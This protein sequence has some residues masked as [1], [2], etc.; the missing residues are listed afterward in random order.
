M[1]MDRRSLLRILRS[2]DAAYRAMLRR[3]AKFSAW[4]SKLTV[5]QQIKHDLKQRMACGSPRRW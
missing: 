4:Y 1:R 2:E 3:Q 5:E